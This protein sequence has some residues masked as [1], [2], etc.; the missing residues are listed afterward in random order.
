MTRNIQL[1]TTSDGPCWCLLHVQQ[2]CDLH[3]IFAFS[4][5]LNDVSLGLVADLILWH[6][7]RVGEVLRSDFDCD[8]L[9]LSLKNFL[10]VI[11]ELICRT[12]FS[13]AVWIECLILSQ[14]NWLCFSWFPYCL[15]WHLKPVHFFRNVAY[16]LNKTWNRSVMR[17]ICMSTTQSLSF[18]NSLCPRWFLNCLWWTT[19]PE[20]EGLQQVCCSKL[21]ANVI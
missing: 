4:V 18:K 5:R 15:S 13:I 21:Q 19:K 14:M 20:F 7:S 6:F 1:M 16:M 10:S 17:F 3:V 12:L 2:L 11:Y 8:D 9:W